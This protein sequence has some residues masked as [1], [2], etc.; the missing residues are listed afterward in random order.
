MRTADSDLTLS[1][2]DEM[3]SLNSHYARARAYMPAPSELKESLNTLGCGEWRRSERLFKTELIRELCKR[4]K[5]TSRMF[6]FRRCTDNVRYCVF[7]AMIKEMVISF[8]FQEIINYYFLH[9]NL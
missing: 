7:C 6:I 5:L 9:C 2:R 4:L 3:I 8:F 1:Y